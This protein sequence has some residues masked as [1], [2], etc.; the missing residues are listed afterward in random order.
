MLVIFVLIRFILTLPVI[1]ASEALCVIGDYWTLTTLSEK[2]LYYAWCFDDKLNTYSNLVRAL[3]SSGN[4]DA[5]I[6]KCVSVLSQLGES[7]PTNIT[8]EIY[9]DEVAKVRQTLIGL[10][11][12]ELLSLPLMTDLDKLTA[13]RFLNHM[14]IV[15]YMSKPA[16]NPI[17]VFRM[18]RMS[19]DFG[20]CNISAI[21]FSRA[22]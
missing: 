12:Q 3:S 4:N 18:V 6:D 10:S 13:M 17:V 16:L 15:T 14:L 1:A 20:V 7:L 8:P 2:P 5:C 19:V 9:F 11:R 21:A 22:N